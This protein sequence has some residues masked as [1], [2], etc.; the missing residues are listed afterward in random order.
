MAVM[1]K[2]KENP[3]LA[4]LFTLGA[5]AS[6]TLAIW[7]GIQQ[8]DVL[9]VTEAE[10]LLYN[11]QPHKAASD[12]KDQLDDQAIVGKCRFLKLE[13]NGLKDAIYV[14]TRDGA[15]PD[16]I[17]D[18]EGDLEDLEDDYDALSCARRLA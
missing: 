15:D 13:I 3:A 4:V 6:A 2:A 7:A 9:H 10:L 12:L 1:Q 16:H 11:S 8:L 5:T 14:R 18:L 17:N